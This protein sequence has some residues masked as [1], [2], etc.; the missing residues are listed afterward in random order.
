M[1]ARINFFRVETE[2]ARGRSW[3]TEHNPGRSGAVDDAALCM[4]TERNNKLNGLLAHVCNTDVESEHPTN[5]CSIEQ[6]I[7]NQNKDD[8]VSWQKINV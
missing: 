7:L 5:E 2:S 6:T 4:T 8:V 1:P 3:S